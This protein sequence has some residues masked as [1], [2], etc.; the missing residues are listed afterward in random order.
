MVIVASPASMA[1]LAMAMATID[2]Q[3]ARS[4][5]AEFASGGMPAVSVI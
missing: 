3:Q 1:R 5:V 2:E 4:T